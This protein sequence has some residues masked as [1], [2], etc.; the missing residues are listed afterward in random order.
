[1]KELIFKPRA[2]Q[3]YRLLTKAQSK[4]E[5]I[6]KTCKE[7]LNEWYLEKVYGIKKEIQSKYLEKGISCE[8]LS[9]NLMSI[10]FNEIFEKNDV[11]FEN[12]FVSGTP[13]VIKDGIVYDLKTSWSALTFPFFD[14]EPDKKYFYQLQTYLWLADLQEARL[15]YCL[16]NTPEHLIQDEIRRFCWDNNIMDCPEEIEKEIF[17]NHNF[18]MIPI[19]KRIKVFEIKRN[20]EVIEEMKAKIITCREFI[21]LNF[22]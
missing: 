11:W 9:I 12:D 15:V 1:M 19:D 18:D 8:E 14:E 6:G 17:K 10:R 20:D 16:I 21:N 7:Y 3:M 2:S 5:P 13:D 22:K 4:S